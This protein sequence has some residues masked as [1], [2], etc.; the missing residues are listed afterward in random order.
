M[1][2]AAITATLL[3]GVALTLSA[4]ADDDGIEGDNTIPR[5]DY[6]GDVGDWDPEWE[7]FE[8]EV[9]SIANQRRSEGANCGSNGD[10]DP[11]PALAVH[12]A[13]TCAARVHAMDMAVNGYFDHS[14]QDGTSPWER[15]EAA[16]YNWSN[17]GENIARG[18]RD[19]AAVMDAWM[20]SDGHCSNIM[21]PNLQELGVGFH[22][23]GNFWV[24]NFGTRPDAQPE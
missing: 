4:C 5:N 6:C 18:Q 3:L 10:F 12:G 17:A 9:L 16:G 1:M 22:G 8:L 11:A 23:D 21:N 14:S 7:A 2:R 19:P 13:L 24:Q 20:S 15:M